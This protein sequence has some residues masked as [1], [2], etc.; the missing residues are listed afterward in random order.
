[1]FEVPFHGPGL[2]NTPLEPVADDGDGLLGGKEVMPDSV[3]NGEK[4]GLAV[5][6]GEEEKRQVY[7]L[8]DLDSEFF[9]N[10]GRKP[11]VPQDMLGK[12][13]NVFQAPF[14]DHPHP[15]PIRG[16]GLKGWAILGVGF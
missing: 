10:R 13:E 9:V 8:L 6:P 1:M 3:G 4:L 2:L 5:A 14:P 15:G 16:L 11:P 12:E 7:I